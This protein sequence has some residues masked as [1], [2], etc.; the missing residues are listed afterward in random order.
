[1]PEEPGAEKVSLWLDSPG[2]G[3]D[4]SVN[5]LGI[6]AKLFGG[7]VAK[8]AGK[9]LDDLFTS[10]EE[11]RALDVEVKKAE[12]SFKTELLKADTTLA[13]GQIEINKEE[14]KSSN[15][16]VAG[17]RPGAAWMCVAGLAYQ[18]LAYPFLTWGSLNF[19]WK[20]PPQL[21]TG[22]LTTLLF[23]MLGLGAARTFEKVK[24]VQ[25]KH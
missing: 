6:V 16:F 20:V 5:P 8:D 3:R 23:G 18:F 13:I 12:L 11:R 15:W 14:A 22:T 7:S 19:S 25:E 17:W 1:M 2:I 9:A 10:D 4:D 24:G 21:D